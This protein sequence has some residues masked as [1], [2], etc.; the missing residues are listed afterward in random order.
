MSV[1]RADTLR[2]RL[3]GLGGR[4]DLPPDE[5]LLLPRCRSVHTVTMRF[6]LDLIWIGSGGG[7]VRVDR[8]VGRFRVR[9]CRGAVAVLECRAGEADRFLAE[10]GWMAELAEL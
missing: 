2:T 9:A 6:A 8:V 10:P 5:A 4:R 7:V 3:R 1:V